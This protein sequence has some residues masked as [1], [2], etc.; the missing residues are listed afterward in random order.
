MSSAAVRLEK[1][2]RKL[3]EVGVEYALL[4]S[5]ASL[6][7][8]AGYTAGIETGPS[9]FAPLLGTLLWERGGKQRLFLADMEST[10]DL[11]DGMETETFAS[12][13]VEKPLASMSDLGAKLAASLKKLPPGKVGV[14]LEEIPAAVLERLRTESPRLRFRDI[15]RE[16]AEIR[17]I[18][19]EEEIRILRECCA[20]CDEGQELT[21]KLARPGIT[22]LELFAATRRG[23]ELKEGGRLPLLADLVSGRRTAEIG[24]P[25][26]TRRIEAGDLIISDLVP[27]HLGYWGDSCNTCVAGEPSA[28]QRK[29]FAG[30]EAALREGVEQVRPGMRACDLDALLRG[31]V[32]RLGGGY[33]HHSGHGVGVSWHEEPRIVPYNTLALQAGMV[34]A[35]EPAIYFKDRFGLRLEH[36]LLVTASGPEVLTQFCHS[37]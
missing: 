7:Y 12:Y 37:L 3:Q 17:M 33:P 4:S 35:L 1:L 6:R 5:L 14:E 18:K 30:I 19:D 8:F 27:R 34:I 11:Y 28:E 20:L 26:S 22:E 16:V 25:P 31:R 32:L 15:A 10:D 9:P 24:G 23:M 13:T 21:K 36:A 29:L 2:S